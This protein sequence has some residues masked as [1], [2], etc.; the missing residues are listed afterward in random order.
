MEVV[1]TYLSIA[2]DLQPWIATSIALA[3][4]I[5]VMVIANWISKRIIVR[6]VMRLLARMSLYGET[7]ALGAVV[8]RL[9]NIVPALVI[10]LGIVLVPGI[11]M[12]VFIVVQN[13]A[14]AFIIMTIGL[15][16]GAALNFANYVYERR[17][18]ARN[19]P[20][21]GFL[22]VTKIIVYG[23]AVILI[24]AALIDR[25][26]VL[27]FS[28]L[29][30]MAAI[31]LLVFKDTL[32]SLV[33]SVQLSSNDM[34]RVGDWIEMP[35][36]NADGDVIDI[37]LHTVK[38]QN[39]DKTITTIPTYRLIEGS[40]KNW[41]GM[42]ESGGRRISRSLLIDQRSIRFLTSGQWDA[43][44]RFALLCPYLESKEKELREWNAKNPDASKNDVNN[45][46]PT[47]IGTFRAYVMAYLNA[48]PC[49]AQ[50]KTLLVRQLAP[51]QTGLP[52][53]IYCF[54]TTTAWDGY[55]SIQ[56]DIFDHLLAILPEFGL[57]LFQDPTSLDFR[58]FGDVE[59][60]RE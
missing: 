29:G 2:N 15:A 7:P 4:L 12:P 10:Q 8:T 26:P 38:V 60:A 31:L 51:T 11:P 40:F 54:T 33:A 53:Q 3:I 17:P 56:A 36:F 16:I 21:K 1:I 34:L 46:R 44:R 24:I 14:A 42:F 59:A 27:L 39:W 28:G 49:I 37:A 57:R 9:S 58:N 52:I 48:H 5:A 18:E 19:R 43:M 13:V 20:I 50:D 41:R 35:Q 30:A 25:S 6:I 45:R 23:V 47:N 55:E 32:L 22:E